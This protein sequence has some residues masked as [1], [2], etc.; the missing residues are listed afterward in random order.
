[1]KN[2][3]GTMD[4]ISKNEY[5]RCFEVVNKSLGKLFS[6]LLPGTH[7]KLV[8]VLVL[9]KKANKENRPRSGDSNFDVLA[10]PEH[11][12]TIQVSF[13]EGST[14]KESL[15][16]L[17]GGQRSLLALSFMMAMLK[18]RS[19]PFYI[20][21][22]ID[23]AMDLSHTEGVGKLIKEEFE[24]SQFLVI[25]L[26]KGM[27]SSANVLFKTNLNEGKSE[28]IRIEQRKPHSILGH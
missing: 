28:V 9:D 2:D 23:A 17:S 3:I 12:I 4:E 10:D 27:F 11:G 16:E 26:K 8:P 19:A 13:D 6:K 5:I 1:M 15:T 18:Y 25:S 7:A 21:D 20:L 22:E 14:Y 24:G